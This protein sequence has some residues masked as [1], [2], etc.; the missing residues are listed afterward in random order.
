MNGEDVAEEMEHWVVEK[1]SLE[2]IIVV[3]ADDETCEVSRVEAV[4][5]GADE[6]P[7]V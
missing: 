2:D 4:D 3:V 7:V 5:V 1:P 6:S